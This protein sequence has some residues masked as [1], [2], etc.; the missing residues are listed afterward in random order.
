MVGTRIRFR[1]FR[2]T[3]VHYTCG[4]KKSTKGFTFEEA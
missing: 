1:G 3:L 4:G 2:G